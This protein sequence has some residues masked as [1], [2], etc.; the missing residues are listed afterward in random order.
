[1]FGIQNQE[2]GFSK[3]R[4]LQQYRS[5]RIRSVRAILALALA[6]EDARSDESSDV[7]CATT[8]ISV[9]GTYVLLALQVL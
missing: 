2:E 1:M 9:S 7:E 8:Y 4:D 6:F 3:Q 5:I